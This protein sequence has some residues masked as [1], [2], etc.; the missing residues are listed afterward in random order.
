VVR[1]EVVKP[2]HTYWYRVV[3]GDYELHWLSIARR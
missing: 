1:V 3:Q 2:G